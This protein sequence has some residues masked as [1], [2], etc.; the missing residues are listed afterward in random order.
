MTRIRN[1][2]KIFA[3]IALIGLMVSCSGMEIEENTTNQA[4]AYGSGK[5]M[6]AAIT[7]L[8]P[9]VNENLGFAWDGLMAKGA[10]L[11]I[12]PPE[13]I[14]EF[15]SAVMGIMALESGDELGLIQDLSVLL[16]IFGAEF[17]VDGEM[18]FIQPVPMSVLRFFE[19]GYDSGVMITNR[20][21][22]LN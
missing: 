5:A 19:M 9:Q 1:I 20:E 8:V 13:Y 16:M 17:G 4:I 10:G 6:G 2:T 3:C 15:Y 7:T 14:L 21:L 12:M 22:Q 11:D 18:T